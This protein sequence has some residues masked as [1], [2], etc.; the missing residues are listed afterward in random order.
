[1]IDFEL[2]E[3]IVNSRQMIHMVAEQLMRPI[4]REYDERE[5]EKPTEFLNTMWK[6]SAGTSF[7]ADREADKKAAASGPKETTSHPAST[8]RSCRGVTRVSI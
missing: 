1:M 7:G 3:N 6:V 2:S 5:H 8:S 4:S